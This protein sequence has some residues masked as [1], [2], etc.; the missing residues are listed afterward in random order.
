MLT[1]KLDLNE[2]ETGIEIQM[3]NGEMYLC[4]EDRCTCLGSMYGNI[5]RHRTFIFAMGGFDELK[6]L[7]KAERRK[8]E[9]AAKLTQPAPAQASATMP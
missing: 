2:P 5:C 8:L 3:P 9:K 7:I 6:K 1:L 4:T